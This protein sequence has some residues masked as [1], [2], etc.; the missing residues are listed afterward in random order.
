MAEHGIL[1]RGAQKSHKVCND[2]LDLLPISAFDTYIRA[3]RGNRIYVHSYCRPCRTRR[4][5]P[6]AARKSVLRTR[7]GLSWDDFL[8]LLESQGGGC[9]VCGA[10][11]PGG[12]GHWHI[13]HDHACCHTDSSKG[14]VKTCGKCVRGVLCH[15]CNT[16]L[17][18]FGDD[19]Q[20]LRA[21]IHYLEANNG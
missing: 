14:I 18:N 7:Y 15:G 5:D 10:R 9:G 19:P 17:G 3:A 20:R 1:S 12:K 8:A 16:G 11:E 2:C 21:A 6:L 4:H 13:D